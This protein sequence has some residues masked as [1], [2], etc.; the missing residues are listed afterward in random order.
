MSE[1][2]SKERA[3]NYVFARN[4]QQS[5][6]FNT[7]NLYGIA[8]LGFVIAAVEYLIGRADGEMISEILAYIQAAFALFGLIFAVWCVETKEHAVQNTFFTQTGL[9]V[10]ITGLVIGLTLLATHLVAPK[11]PAPVYLIPWIIYALSFFV[12]YSVVRARAGAHE[13]KASK[14][15]S[16][17]TVI[18]VII[19][20]IFIGRMIG[21][22]TS[23]LVDSM[24]DSSKGIAIIGVGAL[25]SFILGAL[26][27]VNFHKN[28]LVKKYSID[29]TRLY[30][31]YNNKIYIMELLTGRDSFDAVR[32]QG[33]FWLTGAYSDVREEAK[34][35]LGPGMRKNSVTGQ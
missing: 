32:V 35:R 15:I 24:S 34:I 5:K 10:E 8:I 17:G 13:S 23:G 7:F 31:Y 19:I 6:T 4:A 11:A 33:R 22:G 3:V 2:N 14:T 29:L 25:I 9:L 27:A 21:T 1:I 12:C 30:E 16:F 18:A 28:L 26:T 20:F